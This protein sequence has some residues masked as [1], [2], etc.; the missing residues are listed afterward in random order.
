MQTCCVG[1][2]KLMPLREGAKIHV[3]KTPCENNRTIWA[4]G[5]YVPGTYLAAVH[6][7]CQCNEMVSLH[8][9]HLVA[10]DTKFS[11]KYWRRLDKAACTALG[12]IIEV[13]TPMTLMEVAKGYM[14]RRRRLY[15]QAAVDV[16]MCAWDPDW[17]RVRMFVKPDKHP[18]IEIEERVPRAI[19]YRDPRFN[20]QLARWLKP[21]EQQFYAIQHCGW[22]CIAKTMN[23]YDRAELVTRAWHTFKKPIAILLDHSKFDSSVTVEHLKTCHRWYLRACP[24]PWLR[25]LLGKQ[26]VNKGSTRH[27]IKYRVVGTKMSG[28]YDTA[29]GNTLINYITITQWLRGIHSF[30][31][32]DG[33]DSVVIMEQ[34]KEKEL[35]SML[36]FEKC[37]F[38]TKKQVVRNLEDIEFCHSKLLPDNNP[39]FVRD[40]IRSLSHYQINTIYYPPKVMPRFLKGLALGEL[41][42]VKA[43]P[44]MQA[45]MQE[46]IKNPASPIYSEAHRWKLEHPVGDRDLT[47]TDNDR[48]DYELAWAVG[49]ERQLY[50]ESLAS[51]SIIERVED[52]DLEL[53]M[54]IQDAA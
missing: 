22:P 28:D 23:F 25:F 43:V 45:I 8:N 38:H 30:L 27:G 53:F 44:V 10:R 15:Y 18:A 7:N 3:I 29:L 37:G 5:L 21:Y 6:G 20:I 31:L 42:Q 35:R 16:S 40:A 13:V 54:S 26:L 14:G 32:I 48:V 39:R 52:F 36:H 24:S 33:D 2:V 9:R 4:T 46:L 17:A 34:N 49:I 1:H 50:L 19:Q 11:A 12:S 47:I 51:Q 41:S